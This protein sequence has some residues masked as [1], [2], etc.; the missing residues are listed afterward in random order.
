MVYDAQAAKFR[1][2]VTQE[3][4]I[5]PYFQTYL[6]CVTNEIKKRCTCIR[7]N[8]SYWLNVAKRCCYF[9]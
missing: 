9:H 4:N 2:N 5:S 1:A 7:E 8:K 6:R 3:K